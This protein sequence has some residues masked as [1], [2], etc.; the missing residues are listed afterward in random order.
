MESKNNNGTGTEES[1][2]EQE[3]DNYFV[4]KDAWPLCPR[5]LKPCNPLQSYCENCGAPDAINPLTPYMPFLNIRFNYAVFGT[6]WRKIWYDK[7]CSIIIRLLCVL[8]IVLCA[9][10]LIIFGL[11]LLLIGK[12]PQP[13]L[14]KSTRIA[15]Y[16]IAVALLLLLLCFNLI[17]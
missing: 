6:M 16:I 14:R 15:F 13:R 10:I 2:E 11:P 9:P 1:F 8:L 12:I 3:T 4:P 5:C 17:R 7:D